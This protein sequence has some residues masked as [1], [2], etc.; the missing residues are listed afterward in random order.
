MNKISPHIIGQF[1]QFTLK[2]LFRVPIAH[3]A[4]GAQQNRERE[5][6]R[7]REREREGERMRMNMRAA[8]SLNFGSFLVQNRVDKIPYF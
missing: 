2:K 6:K 1:K 8:D 4:S 3:K 7:E 5:R